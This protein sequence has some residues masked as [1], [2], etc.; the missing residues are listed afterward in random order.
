VSREARFTLGYYISRLRRF[1][2]TRCAHIHLQSG[3]NAAA[4]S[5]TKRDRLESLSYM[6]RTLFDSTRRV[7]L[8]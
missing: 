3:V 2:S 4:L 1:D 7:R 6:P 8:H 5:S